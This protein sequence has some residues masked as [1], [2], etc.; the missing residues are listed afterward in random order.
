M[1]KRYSICSVWYNFLS[2]CDQKLC[3]MSAASNSNNRGDEASQADAGNDGTSGICDGNEMEAWFW[4][5]YILIYTFVKRIT[6]KCGGFWQFLQMEWSKLILTGLKL[7]FAIK[8]KI[9]VAAILIRIPVFIICLF[10][11]DHIYSIYNVYII[12]IY[13]C[14]PV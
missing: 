2:V 6:S 10:F 5:L 7:Y 14:I 9:I 4:Y 13:I 3:E 8:L 12:H 11:H 1:N